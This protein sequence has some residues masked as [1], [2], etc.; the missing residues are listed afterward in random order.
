ME[1]SMMPEYFACHPA[2]AGELSQIAQNISLSK[3]IK[4][5]FWETYKGP[6]NDMAYYMA[7]N[8]NDVYQISENEYYSFSDGI[9]Y[10]QSAEGKRIAMI[11]LKG[12]LTTFH[13]EALS[14][15]IKAAEHP[16]YAGAIIMAD[17][18]GGYIRKMDMLA[19]AISNYSKPIGVWV[20]GNLN[21]A[22]AY[23]TAGADWI[24][25]DIDEEKN[26]FGSIGVFAIAQNVSE[27]NDKNGIKMAVIRSE[28]AVEK[29]IPNAY[30]PWDEKSLAKIQDSVNK[31]G[32]K[33][34][35]VMES[36]RRIMGEKMDEV[37][38]GAEFNT[39]EAIRLGLADSKMS[40]EDAIEKTA[41]N[42]L[43]V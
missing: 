33:F 6:A 11:P 27:Y 1:K 3:E 20:S 41:T 5:G 21:S 28:G 31:D 38:K 29:Y 39:D 40:F 15:M 8:P 16:A 10:R 22:A 14:I 2:W 12:A 7:F 9:R 26:S 17:S 35:A 34:L 25:A 37:K 30:E 24:A 4:K 23:V 32:A 36:K 43:F 42:Q 18:P 19:S 13:Y